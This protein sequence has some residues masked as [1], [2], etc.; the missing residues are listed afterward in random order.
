[1]MKAEIKNVIFDVGNVLDVP[2]LTGPGL[3]LVYAAFV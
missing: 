1:M 2:A 3:E